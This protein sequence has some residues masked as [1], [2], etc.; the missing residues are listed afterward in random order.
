MATLG[1]AHPPA[2]GAHV[3]PSRTPNPTDD[4]LD[5]T[6]PVGDLDRQTEYPQRAGSHPSHPPI[7]RVGDPGAQSPRHVW[8]HVAWQSKWVCVHGAGAATP[9]ERRNP[10]P[11]AASISLPS[12]SGTSSQTRRGGP[13]Q[14]MGMAPQRRECL[15]RANRNA[16]MDEGHAARTQAERSATREVKMPPAEKVGGRQKS[17]W[18]CPKA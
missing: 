4:A 16:F 7:S 15:R 1:W 3:H 6:D 13:H 10:P 11:R 9:P 5:P 2:S 17:R 12:P 18:E 14:L 8:F